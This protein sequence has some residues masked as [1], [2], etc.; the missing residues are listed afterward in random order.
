M[1]QVFLFGFGL[2]VFLFASLTFFGPSKTVNACGEYGPFNF[3][4]FEAEDNVAV[5]SLAIELA[6]EGR[7]ITGQKQ[8]QGSGLSKVLYPGLLRALVIAVQVLQI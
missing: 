5:Y 3:E 1:K 7:L 8:A 6:V 4:T 2:G